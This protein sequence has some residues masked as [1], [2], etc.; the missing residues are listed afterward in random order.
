MKWSLTAAEK[1]W[2]PDKLIRTGI[3]QLLGKRRES[4]LSGNCEVHQERINR[5]LDRW[6]TAP[7]APD[8]EAAR[9]QHYDLPPDFFELMLGPHRKYSCGRWTEDTQTLKDA[10]EAMLRTVEERLGLDAGM[11]LL[12]VGCGWGSLS[13]WLADRHPEVT[14]HALT[15]SPDQATFVR[16]QAA[17]R[18][19]DNLT[20][21]QEDLRSWEPTLTVDRLVCVEVLEH[22]RNWQELFGTLA[23]VLKPSGRMLVHYFCHRS[24]PYPFQ[25]DGNGDWMARNFFTGGIM[26]SRDL[27]YRFNES[28]RVAKSWVH[29][30]IN[31]QQ[32][33]ERWLDNLDQQR[34]AAVELLD[35]ID[36]DYSPERLLQRWRMFVM[37]CSE[38]FG[39][40]N[41]NE[42][43]VAH[44]LLRRTN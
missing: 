38:L 43:F 7:I 11:E 18:N 10:E 27:I 34:T 2:L 15:H 42:W 41:G 40:R 19:L 37:A 32:T 17:Q 23:E 26:P 12:D 13:L 33:C 29:S 9:N 24:Q 25:N 31:Y 36:S 4:I 14:V 30:G 28:L 1:G 39:Y 22:C 8:S 21:H 16:Q 5:L 44:H 20:L 6:A 3:R 35:G